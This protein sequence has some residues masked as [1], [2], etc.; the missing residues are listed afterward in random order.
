MQLAVHRADLTPNLPITDDLG[1]QHLVPWPYA[2]LSA[3]QA[4]TEVLACRTQN[5]QKVMTH[6]LHVPTHVSS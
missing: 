6:S 3:K 4:K 5:W 2:S 1:Q